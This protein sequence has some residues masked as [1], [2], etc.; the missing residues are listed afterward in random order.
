MT[1]RLCCRENA[2]GNAE[3]DE[4]DVA[5]LGKHL[6]SIIG[7]SSAVQKSRDWQQERQGV[8]V[9]VQELRATCKSLDEQVPPLSSA[10]VVEASA[11]WA[12]HDPQSVY[13]FFWI[14]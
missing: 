3:Q 7:M 5:E 11:R 6:E 4:A 14:T 13:V 2:S 9:Q 8:A 12:C 10:R 1:L